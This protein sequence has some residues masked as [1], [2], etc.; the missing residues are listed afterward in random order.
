LVAIHRQHDT[1]AQL[2]FCLADP[3]LSWYICGQGELS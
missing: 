2:R 3:A 1:E